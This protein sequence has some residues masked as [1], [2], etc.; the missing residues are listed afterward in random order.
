MWQVVD[1]TVAI[2][3]DGCLRAKLAACPPDV[4]ICPE[5]GH[6]A[7]FEMHRFESCLAAGIAA[8]RAHEAELVCLRDEAVHPPQS[9]SLWTRLR[10]WVT[11]RA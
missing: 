2:M 6:V 9:P 10:G 5:V 3:Q 11:D 7:L 8:V 1:R 4:M